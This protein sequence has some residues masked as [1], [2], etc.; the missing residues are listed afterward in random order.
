MRPRALTAF[1]FV[2][3]NGAGEKNEKK[4]DDDAAR[5]RLLE[6]YEEGLWVPTDPPAKAF[7]E[8]IIGRGEEGGS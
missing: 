1:C 4:R 5:R 2:Q 8:S 3:A 6:E 7:F